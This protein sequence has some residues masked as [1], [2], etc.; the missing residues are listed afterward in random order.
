MESPFVG[1]R[2]FDKADATQFF[3]R[4]REARDLVSL[5]H[6]HPVVFL[7]A[8]SG[9]G[10]T[11]LV[12][13]AVIPQ[14][15]ADDF[16]VFPP[17][18]LSSPGAA[19]LPGEIVNTYLFGTLLSWAAVGLDAA[20]KQLQE[21]ATTSL[22][23][24]LAE[25]PRSID[26]FGDPKPRLITFDQFEEFLMTWSQTSLEDRR[27]F[28]AQLREG[29]ERDPR[30]RVLFVL[31]EEFIAAMEPYLP[32]LGSR[33]E[34]FRIER[35]NRLSAMEAI[36]QPLRNT[37]RR[38]ADAAATM[39]IENLCKVR[40][41]TLDGEFQTTLGEFLEPVQ[42]QIVCQNLWRQLP[43]DVTE[44]NECDLTAF[45]TV[46]DALTKFYD[47]AIIEA[48]QRTSV[49]E[50]EL[51]KWVENLITAAGTRSMVFRGR[52][53]TAGIPNAAVDILDE[54]HFLRVEL[55]A[56]A[57][58]YE[59]THDRLIEPVQRSNRKWHELMHNRVDEP[60]LRPNKTWFS[61]FKAWMTRLRD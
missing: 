49:S 11:S 54:L 53:N 26:D 31:R 50:G 32:L 59:L 37:G 41:M 36:Q 27:H 5:I 33:P 20:R 40:F 13:A 8:P 15:E 34:R 17:A 14:L 10:K 12:N 45:G 60:V 43:P 52:D 6:A 38:F 25:C 47:E 35:L 57:R 28:C 44:I 56:G 51:R 42:L 2:P 29:L 22:A 46:D 9:A 23:D 24:F 61:R 21:L 30:L 39:L 58:W 19:A 3:G 18:R 1:L 48:V 16:E 55:R 4:D 7:Y